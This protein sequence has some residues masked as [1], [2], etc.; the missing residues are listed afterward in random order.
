MLCIFYCHCVGLGKSVMFLMVLCE[1][2]IGVHKLLTFQAIITFQ[3]RKYNFMKVFLHCMKY[4]KHVL[5][6]RQIWY[7]ISLFINKISFVVIE[8]THF[9]FNYCDYFCLSFI[10]Y[11]ITSKDYTFVL[12][13]IYQYLN[14]RKGNGIASKFNMEKTLSGCLIRN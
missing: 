3:F 6:S 14:S 2:K 4:L 5:E 13:N 11:L 10:S 12:K 1:V 7:F 8:N 9:G